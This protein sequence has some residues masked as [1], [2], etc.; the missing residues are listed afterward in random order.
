V[1][2]A[3]AE[4]IVQA[5]LLEVAVETVV[6]SW[7]GFREGAGGLYA[8]SG[9]STLDCCTGAPFSSGSFLFMFTQKSLHTLALSLSHT[10][11]HVQNYMPPVPALEGW[12]ER[13][14]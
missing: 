1:A 3:V 2:L 10:H 4:G 6:Q 8:A 5:L 11:T 14:L 13:S 7:L 9:G 12:A